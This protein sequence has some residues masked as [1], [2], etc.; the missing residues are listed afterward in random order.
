[1]WALSTSTT[2]W[3]TVALLWA[4][5]AYFLTHMPPATAL[6]GRPAPVAPRERGGGNTDDGTR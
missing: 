2:A 4:C 6:N 3:L 1:M 5:A